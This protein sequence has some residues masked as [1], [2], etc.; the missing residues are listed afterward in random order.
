MTDAYQPPHAFGHKAAAAPDPLSDSGFDAVYAAKIEPELQARELDREGAVRAFWLRLGL[1]MVVTGVLAGLAWAWLD[2]TA[3]SQAMVR[4]L[5]LTAIGIAGSAWIAWRPLKRVGQ[6]TKRD[7]LG[8]LCAPMGVTYALDRFDPPSF[9]RFCTLGMLGESNERS[10]EDLFQGTRDGC[11]FALYE[12]NLRRRAGKSAVQVFRGQLIRIGFPKRFLG[13]TIVLR[14][15]GFFNRFKH[16]P[17]M[18]K[19]GLGDA[20]FERTFEVYGSD[21]VEA[22]FLVHPAFMQKLLDLEAAYKGANLRCAFEGGDLLLAVEGPDMFE[23][24]DLFE[25]LVNRERAR[26]LDADLGRVLGLIDAVL[27]GPPPAYGAGGSVS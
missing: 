7:V 26:K 15:A 27:A 14:D 22:R 1:G 5:Q 24:G 6:E 16:F 17:G 3:P 9:D 12:A 10:F 2:R 19:V 18:Q 23:I 20:G 21:Q 25:N 13:T 4:L 8:A 11:A